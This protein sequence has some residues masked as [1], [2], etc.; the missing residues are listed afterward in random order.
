MTDEN[1]GKILAE[2]PAGLRTAIETQDAEAFQCALDEL[3][4]EQANEILQQLEAAGIVGMGVMSEVEFQ[5]ILSEFKLLIQAIVDVA[6]GDDSQRSA[7]LAVLPKLDQAGYHLEQAV[8][9]LWAGERRGEVLT[10]GLDPNSARLVEHLLRLVLGERIEEPVIDVQAVASTIPPEV[11]LAVQMQDEAAFDQAMQALSP[12]DRQFVA[13]QLARLQAQADAEAE[14]W[15]VNLPVDVRLAVLDRDG[16]RLQLA[17][18]ELAPSQAQEILDQLEA[19]G[20]LEELDEPQADLL[21]DEFEPLAQAAASVVQGNDTARPLLESLLADMDEQGWHLSAA[22]WRIW[23]GERDLL[24][25]SEGLEYP[26]IQIVQRIL[27]ILE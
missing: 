3:P 20:V 21:M 27:T 18:Q 2:L 6:C 5:S 24:T 10:A 22:V 9:D 12:S 23:S 1:K 8:L 15:L 19:A 17:L 14:K 13:G 25:L 26:D 7:V 16:L 11:L 4:S